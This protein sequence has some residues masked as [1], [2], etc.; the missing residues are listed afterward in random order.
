MPLQLYVT[1]GDVRSVMQQVRGA[2]VGALGDFCVDAYWFI[3]PQRE[4]WSIETGKRVR[5]VRQQRYTLG[6]AGNVVANLVAL[7]VGRI[8]TF[9]VIGPDLYGREMMRLLR[10]LSVNAEGM[11]IQPDG[12]ETPVYG[13]PYF[14][15]EELERQDFGAFNELRDETWQQLLARVGAARDSL[16]FLIVNQQLPHGWCDERRAGEMAA[17]LAK[18]GGRHLIDTRHFAGRFGDACYKLNEHEASRMAGRELPAEA[19]LTDEQVRDG[20]C[21]QDSARLREPRFITR[22]ERGIAVA[23]DGEVAFIPGITITGP[24]DTVGAG[25]TVTATLAACLACRVEPQRAA[26]LANLAASVTVRKINQ[27]GTANEDELLSA[28]RGLAYVF[29]PLLAGEPRRAAYLRDT[30]LEIVEPLPAEVDLRFAVFDHDGTVSTLRQGWENVM[31]PVMIKAILG[32]QFQTADSALFDTVQRRVQE[33]VEQSTGIQ[34]ILQMDG[35]VEMVAEFG[36]VP[37]AQRLDAFGY[38]AVYNEALMQ[39]VDG[40]TARIARGELAPGDFI[41]KG[42]VEFLGALRERGV[43]LF[44]ASGTDEADV[45]RE[46]EALGYAS[47]FDGGIFGAKPGSRADSKEAVIRDIIAGIGRRGDSGAGAQVI[48]TM[49]AGDGPVE[50]RLARRHGG[51]ALGVASHEERR[52]GLN[53]SKR[54]R[55]IRA[56]AHAV[57]PDFSQWRRWLGFLFRE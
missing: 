25:D 28:A 23:Q 17:E 52:F 27:T 7:G 2:R 5:H 16:D 21:L 56:G 37:E 10:D 33:F 50:I 54:R 4:E 47:L 43:T 32:D 15:P 19:K 42:T 41:M 18:W 53:E 6:A 9:G 29:H 48:S 45:V 12:W 35:L 8:E 24:T 39:M 55:V 14:G 11:L 22:G 36:I 57:V 31:A 38:K 20:L 3:D 49:V 44:L 1:E 26:V 46:A 34:T 40:R 51:L 13:K 30:D